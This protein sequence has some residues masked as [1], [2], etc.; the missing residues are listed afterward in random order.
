MK[1][2]INISQAQPSP[3][4]AY[5]PLN[6]IHCAFIAKAATP[7]SV[8]SIGSVETPSIW[9]PLSPGVNVYW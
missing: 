6:L 3:N 2:K 9:G 7:S 1:I 8:L 5:N 4:S